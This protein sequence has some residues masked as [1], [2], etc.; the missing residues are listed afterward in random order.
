MIFAK[1]SP[2]NFPLIVFAVM[3]SCVSPSHVPAEGVAFLSKCNRAHVTMHR[4]TSDS[5]VTLT[6]ILANLTSLS[7]ELYPG[8]QRTHS[9]WLSRLFAALSPLCRCLHV[10]L[11][12]D[13]RSDLD[14]MASDTQT[15][16]DALLDFVPRCEQLTSLRFSVSSPS[17]AQL[18]TGGAH[19]SQLLRPSDGVLSHR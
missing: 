5:L 4:F 2:F 14:A 10:R 7:L 3:V 17:T 18:G 15:L 8:T 12:W 19:R 1:A 9:A 6:P 11:H 13:L 16:L